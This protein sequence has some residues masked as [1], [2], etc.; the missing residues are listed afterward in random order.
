MTSHTQ[1]GNAA[2]SS[3]EIEFV[4]D[5]EVLDPGL[6]FSPDLIAKRLQEL[7]YLIAGLR[8]HLI[9]PDTSNTYYEP[10]GLEEYVQWWAGERTAWQLSSEV[11]HF[12]NETIDVAF[13]WSGIQD[14]RSLAFRSEE[15]RV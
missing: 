7:A 14:K 12:Q 8:L 15:R 3:T 1:K 6:H 2:T 11:L 5:T 4:Y 13:Q 10:R 9:T